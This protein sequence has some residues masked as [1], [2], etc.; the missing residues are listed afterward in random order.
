MEHTERPPHCDINRSIPCRFNYA[1]SA[2]K[3]TW[4]RRW[5]LDN[6]EWCS[7]KGFG[8]SSLWQST[9]PAC[10]RMNGQTDGQICEIYS[11]IVQNC[12]MS[13]PWTDAQSTARAQTAQ[14]QSVLYKASLYRRTDRCR[15][16]YVAGTPRPTTLSARPAVLSIASPCTHLNR[17][18]NVQQYFG[19]I[20]LENV[21]MW[22]AYTMS[23]VTNMATMR[24]DHR[25][26]RI[27]YPYLGGK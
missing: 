10:T 24:N 17:G 20:S 11:A 6:N 1:V 4:R 22:Q 9:N 19:G 3:V 15:A 5:R 26:S 16:N 8:R 7:G 21:G 27:N 25:K 12:T 14:W 2:A 13:G 18:Q 23:K